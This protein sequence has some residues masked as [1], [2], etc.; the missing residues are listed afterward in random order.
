MIRNEKGQ[1]IIFAAVM[2]MVLM[3]F[4]ALVVNVTQLVQSR[5]RAQGAADFSALAGATVQA[6]GL[7]EIAGLNQ[8]IKEQYSYDLACME[9][10]GPSD[11]CPFHGTD[12]KEHGRVFRGTTRREALA[13]ALIH[14][15]E[16]YNTPPAEDLDIISRPDEQLYINSAYA[17]AAWIAARNVAF[18]NGIY[19]AYI[20]AAIWAGHDSPEVNEAMLAEITDK[21]GDL[22]L[23]MTGREFYDEEY[24]RLRN[25]EDNYVRRVGP[26]MRFCL[27][28]GSY[29]EHGLVTPEEAQ[30]WLEPGDYE[31][32]QART[33]H[34]CIWVAEGSKGA[35]MFGKNLLDIEIPPLI[36]IA[37]AAAE[38]GRIGF[39]NLS[40]YYPSLVPVNAS[41]EPPNRLWDFYSDEEIARILH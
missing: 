33:S 10:S 12:E 27:N 40:D 26:R 5:Q 9:G 4:F 13:E 21:K 31:E 14:Y 23:N 36:A 8:Q 38:G 25:L 19:D 37:Q 17:E 2:F 41:L 39:D 1:V 34:F 28:Y 6:E 30:L 18:A 24:S 11:A 22:I 15:S 3:F 7:N 32:E 29:W 35:A 20:D 16:Y